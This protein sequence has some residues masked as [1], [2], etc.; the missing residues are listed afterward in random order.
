[1]QGLSLQGVSWGACMH[2]CLMQATDPSCMLVACDLTIQNA[3]GQ[4]IGARVLD[5]LS[6]KQFD[7]HAR[8][9]INATVRPAARI[10]TCW[11]LLTC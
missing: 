8:V 7:I 11:A 4:V 3:E 6:G 10:S 1:M 9:V 2:V 5:R